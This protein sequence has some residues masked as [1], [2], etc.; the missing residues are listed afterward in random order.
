MFLTIWMMTLINVFFKECEIC[1]DDID[2]CF[3]SRSARYVLQRVEAVIAVVEH[4][5][6]TLDL[7]GKHISY[8]LVNLVN[9]YHIIW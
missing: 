2:E 8:H 7:P 1:D 6:T 9:I 3:F 4:F 5:Q